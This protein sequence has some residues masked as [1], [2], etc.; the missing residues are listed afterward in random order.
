MCWQSDRAGWKPHHWGSQVSANQDYHI[1]YLIPM[2]FQEAAW[3]QADADWSQF[4]GRSC[5][6]PWPHGFESL[7]HCCAFFYIPSLVFGGW[8]KKA[9][10]A[11]HKSEGQRVCAAACLPHREP[12]PTSQVTMA[13]TFNPLWSLPST[14]QG[15][16]VHLYLH[17]RLGYCPEAQSCYVRKNDSSPKKTI[18]DGVTPL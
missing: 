10:A 14:G 3:I 9:A 8:G 15:E 12:I 5:Q 6:H 1:S 2:D 11:G 4:G 7:K 18:T 13:S 16:G 17:P